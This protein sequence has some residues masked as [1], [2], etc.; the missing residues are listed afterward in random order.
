MGDSFINKCIHVR[1]MSTRLVFSWKVGAHL[2]RFKFTPGAFHYRFTSRS[3]GHK[4]K[5]LWLALLEGCVCEIVD[6]SCLIVLHIGC[7]NP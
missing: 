5:C 2:S 1:E 3:H 4:K 6:E 7:A